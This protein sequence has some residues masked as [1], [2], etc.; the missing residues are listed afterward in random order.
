L[1]YV[2]VEYENSEV[3]KSARKQ[4]L[5]KMFSERSVSCGFFDENQYKDKNLDIIDKVI[6]TF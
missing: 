1:G 5:S 4:F 2:F 6:I 3:A